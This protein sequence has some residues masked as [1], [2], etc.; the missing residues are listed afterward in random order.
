MGSPPSAL[1]RVVVKAGAEKRLRALPASLQ[2]RVASLL[3]SLCFDAA[4]H[5][6]AP[7][8]G[9]A[10]AYRIRVG[11]YR[12]VYLRNAADRRVTVFRIAHRKDVYRG[13]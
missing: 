12:V 9:F 11:D 4:P 7:L 2:Q 5:G 8:K 6:A 3:T 13:L 1:Y 10:S